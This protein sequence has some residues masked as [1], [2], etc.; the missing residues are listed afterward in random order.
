MKSLLGIVQG[1]LYLCTL[2]V[3]YEYYG[4]LNMDV[5]K[6][7]HHLLLIAIL[8]VSAII[9]VGHVIGGGLMGL[10]SGGVLSGMRLGLILGLGVGLSRL[11]P[12]C[13]IIGAVALL[14]Q[15]PAWHWLVAFALAAIFGILHFMM[16]HVWKSIA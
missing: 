16:G 7:I 4:E 3:A 14:N 13:A 8:G 11:W 6:S 1:F 2:A 10:T 9:A 15:A 12:Y 5:P